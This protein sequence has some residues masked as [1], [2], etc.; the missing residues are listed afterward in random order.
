MKGK[1]Q[2]VTFDPLKKFSLWLLQVLLATHWPELSLLSALGYKGDEEGESFLRHLAGH[3]VIKRTA[4]V[5]E[6]N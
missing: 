4:K 1:N 5:W 3:S 6:A 2:K